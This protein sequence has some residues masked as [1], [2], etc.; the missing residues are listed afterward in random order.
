MEDWELV[1]EFLR[2]GVFESS[3]ASIPTSSFEEETM[4][5]DSL[6]WWADLSSF[7][8]SVIT[9]NDLLENLRA[10]LHFIK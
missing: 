10:V 1:V 5:I 9:L 4:D 3:L 6:L 7:D 2:V 8:S